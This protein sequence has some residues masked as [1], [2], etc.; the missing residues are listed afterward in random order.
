MEPAMAHSLQFLALGLAASLLAGCAQDKETFV[1]NRTTSA[2][3][4]HGFA[5]ATV[6]PFAGKGSPIYKGGQ[7]PFGGGNV[8]VG[9][10]YQVAG[11]WFYPKEQPGY[12]KV[13]MASWYGADFHRRKTANGEWFDM[14]TL[15]AAHPTLP[16][17]SYAVV[18]NLENG[19]NVVVRVN[20]RGPFV[21]TRMVDLSK[22][23]ADVLGYRNK[24]KTKVRL[25]LLGPAPKQDSMAHV[26]AMNQA[27]SGGASM[28]QLAALGG[29]TRITASTQV[30]AAEL[31]LTRMRRSP[32]QQA[33]L[34]GPEASPNAFVVRV[35]VFHDLAN[36]DAAVQKLSSFGPTKIVKAVGANG[37]L[38]RVEI[39]PIDN[40]ADADAAL[41][42]AIGT[43]YEDAKLMQDGSTQVSM[44]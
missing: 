3:R 40:K 43:G 29:N 19:R 15:T 38:F 9:K 36:A 17:P 16:L 11:R 24:G 10:P 30:A 33:S 44:R 25:R 7:I 4:N 2:K 34:S 14:E 12:D 41:T 39:G 6:D 26:M 37:P 13:G 23:A 18:T 27:M 28:T 35:A 22:R 1:S 20:D 5:S 21:G 32:V 42:T 31:P 8:Q